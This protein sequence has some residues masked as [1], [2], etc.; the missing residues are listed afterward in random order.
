[1]HRCREVCATAQRRVL[2]AG[3]DVHFARAGTEACETNAGAVMTR[4]M[5]SC[6]VEQP[7][8]QVWP[9]LNARSLRCAPIL[10]NEGR[11]LGVV[12]A[13]DI[14]RA[15]IDE[16]THEEEL[17]RDYVMGIGYR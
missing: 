11:P 7:L 5:V 13:R 12:H 16:E 6:C 4:A 17:L 14:A 1:M 9:T 2:G 8:Q 15:L 3:S 10:D